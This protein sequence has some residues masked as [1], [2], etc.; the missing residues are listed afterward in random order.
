MPASDCPTGEP[1]RSSSR[2]EQRSAIRADERRKIAR[3]LHD[4][5]SQLLAV[6]QLQLAQLRRADGAG[7]APLIEECEETIRQIREEIRGLGL[8]EA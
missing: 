8:D 5:T 7:A 2:E 4:S 6:L 3:E 1:G